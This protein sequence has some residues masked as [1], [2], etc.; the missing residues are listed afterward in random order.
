[1]N[2]YLSKYAALFA[3]ALI[4]LPCALARAQARDHLT[5]E[6]ADL[7]RESQEL[8][9][10][11]QVFVKAAERRMLAA[12]NPEEFARESAKDKEKWGEGKGTRTQLIYDV[13]QIL[14]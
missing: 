11:T 1:M 6:E 2:K 13:S 7:V 9:K 5:P 14:E 12:T 10:R 8:D 3:L 4:L